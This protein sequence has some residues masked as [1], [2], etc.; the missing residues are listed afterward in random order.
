MSNARSL[1]NLKPSES[2]QVGTS[3][4]AD[5]AVTAEKIA[6][7]AIPQ[8]PEIKTPT[9]VTPANGATDIG[10]AQ[11]LTG[12]TYYSL[13]GVSMAAAQWQLSTTTSFTSPVYSSGDQAASTTFAIPSGTLSTSTT[14]Y[15]RV[16]YKDANG[17]YS[18]WSSATSFT[19][20]S[21]F[22]YSVDY[23]V[24]AGGG[25]GGSAWNSSGY[26]IAGAGG[27]AG[28]YLSGTTSLAPSTDYT[29]TVGAGGA[30]SAYDTDTHTNGSNSS[31]ASIAT[32]IG[33]GKGGFADSGSSGGSGGGSSWVDGGL[34][35]PGQGND[36]GDS[37][38]GFGIGA[39]G[40]GGAGSAGVDMP[41]SQLSGTDGGSGATWYDG[42]G[43]AGG[44]GGGAGA[45]G[46]PTGG[47]GTSG[48]G[49]GGMGANS[50]YEDGETNK[51]GGGGGGLA[52][53]S[54]S[55]YRGGNGGSG[56][57]IIRYAGSQRGT[58]GTVTSSGGYTYHTFNSSGTYT[59]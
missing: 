7:G 30:S 21:L 8:T 43:R 59:A 47:T 6:P 56:V 4:I 52:V 49:D 10:S 34:G 15:W 55:G 12:S 25:S 35:T 13:Y 38:G 42:V 53:N 31:L 37:I 54:S 18:E 23:L 57:V 50:G 48:G 41:G 46:G 5:S 19:T 29:V 26:K 51:G 39:A 27:G 28:G 58:G 17:V 24:V 33:G 44:G 2:G 45:L 40:G 1:S 32:A 9:N 16:R 36:G 11:S 14:Y 20:A 3:S 22:I